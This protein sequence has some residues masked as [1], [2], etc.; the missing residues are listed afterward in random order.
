MLPA[1]NQRLE[2]YPIDFHARVRKPRRDGPARSCNPS[3][4]QG[5]SA[6]LLGKSCKSLRYR[7]SCQGD[8]WAG[9]P[10]EVAKGVVDR[11][12]GQCVGRGRVKRDLLRPAAA[13]VHWLTEG[14]RPPRGSHRC[15]AR[16]VHTRQRSAR[17]LRQSQEQQS[18]RGHGNEAREPQHAQAGTMASGLLEKAT[19]KCPHPGKGSHSTR[20]RVTIRRNADTVNRRSKDL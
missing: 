17:S 15:Q 4:W 20:D 14:G 3:Q 13:A 2:L 10:V 11:G 18:R 19:K 12:A 1:R 9:Q 6:S 16:S 5:R 7:G 8:R